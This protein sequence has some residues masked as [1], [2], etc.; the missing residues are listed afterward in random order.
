MNDLT[1]ARRWLALFALMLAGESIYML[2]YMRKSFQ[3][4]M[5]RT[6]GV[7]AVELGVVNAMFGVLALL[8]YLPGGWLA[9]RFSTRHLLMISL[10]TTGL[11]GL[12]LLSIPSY[13]ELL[14]IHAFWG[15]TSILTFWAALIKA[16]R[17]WGGPER[18]GLSF[19]LLDGGRGLIGA[20]LVS[21]ATLAFAHAQ[22]PR[23]GLAAAILIYTSATLLAGVAVWLFVPEPRAAS[24]RAPLSRE[25]GV[26]PH[27]KLKDVTA[28]RDVWALAIIV[29]TAYFLFLGTYDF[30]AYAE[31]GF[32]QDAVFGAQLATFR[33]WLRP[34]AA[35]GAGLLA[36]RFRP[37]DTV[38]VAFALLGLCYAGLA[39]TP[40]G[41]AWLWMLWIQVG[42]VALAVFALRG[43]YYAVME[44]SG[45]PLRLT[46]T[47]VGLV[48]LVG[49]IPDIIAPVLSGWLVVSFAGSEGYRY[50]FAVLAGLAMIGLAAT[51]T[52]APFGQRRVA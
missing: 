29:F 17:D 27:E 21:A 39:L 38:S 32:E 5:E 7:D 10:F 40:P 20:L 18:Q 50:Y 1:G 42:V 25:D 22:T 30:P 26:S 2:P 4:T 36:D 47:T 3:T 41:A 16:T 44:Q 49:Y 31:R 51:R 9:D 35:I 52:I 33:D 14:A 28:R 13:P 24:A 11:G 45:I 19:G 48:S 6:Y 12:Y 34:F 43:V 46:G 15:I 37:T 8:C 23:E